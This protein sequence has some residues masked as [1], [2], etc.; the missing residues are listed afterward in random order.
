MNNPRKPERKPERSGRPTTNRDDTG[1]AAR[2]AALKII[3]AVPARG[4]PF[5]ADT[6]HAQ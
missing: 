3:Q 2:R 6:S 1:V 5:A 4:A